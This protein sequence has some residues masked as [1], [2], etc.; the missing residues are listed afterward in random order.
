MQAAVTNRADE[1]RNAS[2]FLSL[3]NCLLAVCRMAHG[4]PIIKK[5]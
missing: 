1:R 2:Q 4:E 5:P 3:A